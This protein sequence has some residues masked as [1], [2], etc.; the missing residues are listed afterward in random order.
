[1]SEKDV[2]FEFVAHRRVQG[3]ETE[4]QILCAIG[5]RARLADGRRQ[6]QRPWQFRARV[7]LHDHRRAG[8]DRGD[9]VYFK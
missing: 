7:Q 6:A 2:A 9:E 8:C 3:P 5:A 1:M 4:R